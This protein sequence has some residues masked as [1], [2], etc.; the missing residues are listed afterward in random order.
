MKTSLLASD[1]ILRIESLGDNCELGFVLRNL[2][3]EAGSLFRW[4]AMEPRQLLAQLRANFE[5]MYEFSNLQPSRNA[6]VV[7]AAYGVGWHSNMQSDMV[8][9]RQRFLLDEDKRR[10]IYREEV[11]KIRDL[12]AKFIARAQLGGLIFVVKSNDGI[13]GENIESIFEAISELAMGARFALLEV[14][15]SSDPGLIGTVVQ[16][17]PGLLRGYVS[18]FASYDEANVVDMESWTSVLDAALRLF[19]CPDWSRRIGELHILG[20]KIALAFPLAK[21]QDLTKPIPGDLRAGAATLLHGNTWCRQVGD[22]FRLHGANPGHPETLLRWTAVHAPGP[23]QLYGALHCPV[24]DSIAVAVVVTVRD[25][26]GTTIAEWRAT[27]APKE[28]EDIALD[29]SSVNHQPVNIELTV[30]AS[31]VIESGERAVVDVSP[32]A[33]DPTPASIVKPGAARAVS[34]VRARAKALAQGAV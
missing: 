13:N 11:R 21:S 12:Q 3:C 10:K 14:Q 32:L 9:G 31:R 6:M 2:G 29:F 27:I 17:H 30:S 24:D 4:T 20:A 23:C 28:P 22:A 33:L 7:D 1:Q 18:R 16:R 19:A 8:D 34:V 5:G 25:D 26:D 15:A